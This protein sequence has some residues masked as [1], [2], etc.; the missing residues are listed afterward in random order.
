MSDLAARPIYAT[1]AGDLRQEITSG[2]LV[3]GDQIPTEA[4]LCDHYRVSRMTVRQA[5]DLL[6]ASGYLKRQRGKGTFVNSDKAER[7]ASRLLGFEEDSLNRGLSPATRVLGSGW[8]QAGLE[9]QQLL[10]LP[11][12]ARI[13]QVDRLRTVN[14]EPIG[15]N[16]IVLLERWGRNLT[17]QDF[18]KSLYAILRDSLADEVKEAEQR[19]EAV[20][21]NNEQADLLQVVPG[22][23]LLRIVRT[24][25]LQRHG[26]IGLTR[27]YYRGDRY[28]LSLTVSRE[29]LNHGGHDPAATA[30]LATPQEET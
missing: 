10:G 29:S 7:S 25:Y 16:H 13:L 9:E 4:E 26:L 8:H 1:I 20:P 6:V 12:T 30:P 2:A 28:F 14:D 11:R 19:I 18:R 17:D 3:V 15:I 24:T 27:T 22:A 23:P 21:A 5:I